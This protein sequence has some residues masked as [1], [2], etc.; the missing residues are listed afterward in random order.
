MVMPLFN[1]RMLRLF[2]TKYLPVYMAELNGR[3]AAYA[4]AECGEVA[5]IHL[6]L[7]MWAV[8][9]D[10]LAKYVFGAE[11]HMLSSDD[12]AR[13][14]YRFRSINA[15]RLAGL[16][17][18]WPLSLLFKIRNLAISRYIAAL[19]VENICSSRLH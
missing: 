13:P 10:I 2:E 8:S 12:L 7:L 5:P 16:F 1:G 3:L 11:L 6:A 9:N 17:R 19:P 14:Y 4:S 18:Q 15:T